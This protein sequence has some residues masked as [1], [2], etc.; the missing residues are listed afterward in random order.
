MDPREDL[1]QHYQWLR[2]YGCN[3]SHSGNASVRVD[4][5]FWVTP[6]GACADLLGADQLVRCEVNGNCGPGASLDGPMHRL[7]YQLNPKARAMLHSHGPH[8]V[9][10]TLHGEDFI[11]IDFEGQYYFP[12]VPVISIPYQD[13]VAEAPQRVAE[14]LA[15]YPIMVVRGH[16]VYAQA[17][18]INLAYKWSCSLEL[19]AKTAWLARQ[20]GTAP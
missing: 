2:Q 12:R 17:E 16:G 6:S 13:Y 3:D 9:A 15:E 1:V 10:L 19:S 18:S 11:P 14:V 8:T 7:V 5:D 20:E 4:N